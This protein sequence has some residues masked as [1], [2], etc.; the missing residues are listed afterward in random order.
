MEV[1][2][3]S[4]IQGGNIFGPHAK[5]FAE[6]F[7]ILHCYCRESTIRGSAALLLYLNRQ[8]RLQDDQTL[9]CRVDPPNKGCLGEDINSADVF[10]VERLSSLGGS[11]CIV[12]IILGLKVMSF[13][14]RLILCF[15]Q[16]ESTIAGFTVNSTCKFSC[17][18]HMVKSR[19]KPIN[20]ALQVGAICVLTSAP[21]YPAVL[22]TNP[23]TSTS[24]AMGV[25]LN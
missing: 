13:V 6:W 16:G 9:V 3:V 5:L 14:G 10:F 22:P 20:Y 24:S 18:L 21:E 11:K 7:I 12:G 19:T 8:V 25:D 23:S 2:N 1:Q 4:E 17:F 15:Y